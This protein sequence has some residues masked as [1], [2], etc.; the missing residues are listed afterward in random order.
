MKQFIYDINTLKY[1][2]Y[3]VIINLVTFLLS[4]KKEI[5]I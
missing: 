4:L 5:S 2:L 1:V 3:E